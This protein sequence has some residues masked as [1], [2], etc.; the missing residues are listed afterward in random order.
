MGP[1]EIAISFAHEVRSSAVYLSS[2]SCSWLTGTPKVVRSCPSLVTPPR[3][4]TVG[5]FLMFV[6]PGPRNLAPEPRQTFPK[7]LSTFVTTPVTRSQT[8]ERPS[9]SGAPKTVQVIIYTVET[10]P[11]PCDPLQGYTMRDNDVKIDRLGIKMKR[12]QRRNGRRR[13]RSSG[14]R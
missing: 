9:A 4:S 13:R 7:L 8:T 3:S 6:R 10:M 14:E 5:D 2:A 12:Y 11:L 1:P